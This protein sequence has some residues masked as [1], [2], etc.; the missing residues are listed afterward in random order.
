[1]IT[2]ITVVNLSSIDLNLLHVL[3][4]ALEE[5]SATRAARRLGV[6]QPAV[7]NALARARDLLDDPLLVRDGR[8]LSPTP[9]AQAILPE[10]AAAMHKLRSVLEPRRPFDPRSSTR[11]LTLACADNSQ[12]ADVPPLAAAL[13]REMPLARLRVVSIDALMAAGGLSADGI[14]MAIGLRRRQPGV[15][16]APLYED[17]IAAVV[18][19]D[20]PAVG[21]R[22]TRS[23]FAR[24]AFIDVHLALGRPGA[25]HAFVE[26]ALRARGLVRR[27]GLVVPGFSAAAMAAAGTDLVALMPLRVARAL[28]SNLPVRIVEQPVQDLRIDMWLVWHERTHED[29]AAAH[30]RKL[31][32]Q[33][34]RAPDRPA[35]G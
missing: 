4:V 24:L 18:R 25:G 5:R 27:I 11:E 21:K 8:G 12:L 7:S 32:V 3:A 13:A 15:R 17:P 14:D 2:F 34:L 22:L 33:T 31:I 10:L 19:R 20:H 9:A 16:V 6:T 1:M 35:A 30:L 29:P 28:A 26:H 23:A